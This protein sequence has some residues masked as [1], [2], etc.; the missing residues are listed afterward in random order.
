MQTDV[1]FHLQVEV[2]IGLTA[3]ANARRWFEQKKKH[4]VKQDK[5]KAAHEKAFK[6]AEKKTLQQLAQ[7]QS[8][9]I[10]MMLHMYWTW[11]KCV[12]TDVYSS[13]SVIGFLG[14]F[15]IVPHF[16]DVATSNSGKEEP[17]FQLLELV[18]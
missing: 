12:H 18:Y 6:A 7:V 11:L 10:S 15:R 1:L 16:N 5:T 8:L 17:W 9:V 2:D 3:H 4:A 14:I 13:E